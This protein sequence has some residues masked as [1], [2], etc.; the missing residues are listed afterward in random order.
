MTVDEI[1][2]QIATFAD[3]SED[4]GF[5]NS[6]KL[7]VQGKWA[8]LVRREIQTNGNRSALY[9][10]TISVPLTRG[11]VETQCGTL[12]ADYCVVL[13][14]TTAIP[15]YLD[16]KGEIPYKVSSPDRKV[17][18]EYIQPENYQYTVHS[19][20]SK[21]DF[22]YSLINQY[23]YVYGTKFLKE[24]HLTFIP[25]VPDAIDEFNCLTCES[26]PVIPSWMHDAIIGMIL[27]DLSIVRPDNDKEEIDERQKA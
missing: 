20:Y 5:R 14:S 9:S 16:I 10:Q 27:D 7:A 4:E 12:P 21:N 25:D 6:V 8:L 1:T 3:R 22:Y 19:K 11:A 13:K 2:Y 24:V 18:L 15:A 23:L 26:Q 17:H